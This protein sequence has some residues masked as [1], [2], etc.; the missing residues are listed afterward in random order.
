[1]SDQSQKD[2]I[3]LFFSR[4]DTNSER[5]T[6]FFMFAQDLTYKRH[7]ILEVI[8][9]LGINNDMSLKEQTYEPPI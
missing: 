3:K 1:M 8:K 9:E 7:L 6:V 2:Q 4:C 5:R